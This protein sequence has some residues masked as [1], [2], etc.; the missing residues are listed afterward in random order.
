MLVGTERERERESAA[1]RAELQSLRGDSLIRAR[2][3][4]PDSYCS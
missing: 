2:R 3:A 4:P 1:D